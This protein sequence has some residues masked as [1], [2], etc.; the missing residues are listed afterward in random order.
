M[1]CHFENCRIAYF[2][3]SGNTGYFEYLGTG[4]VTADENEIAVKS[5]WIWRG[6]SPAQFWREFGSQILNPVSREAP[7]NYIIDPNA[8]L[9]TAPSAN[10][11]APCSNHQTPPASRSYKLPRGWTRG[12]DPQNRFAYPPGSKYLEMNPAY[13]QALEQAGGPNWRGV[14]WDLAKIAGSAIWAGRAAVTSVFTA[15]GLPVSAEVK[16]IAELAG[17]CK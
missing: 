16:T 13:S 1:A 11:K 12:T 2:D 10:K 14:G 7:E 5:D 8:K 15:L 17:Q 3:K 9:P 6:V 4:G